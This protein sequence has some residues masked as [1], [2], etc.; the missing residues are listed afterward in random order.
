MLAGLFLV[1]TSSLLVWLGTAHKNSSIA[2]EHMSEKDAMWFPVIGSAVLLSLFFALKFLPKEIMNI[3]LNLLFLMTGTAGVYSTIH[4]GF[5][6]FSKAPKPDARKKDEEKEEKGKKAEKAAAGD[7]EAARG[8]RRSKE[9]SPSRSEKKER[10]AKKDPEVPEKTEKALPATSIRTTLIMDTVNFV[11]KAIEQANATVVSFVSK[12]GPVE[13]VSLAIA[14]AVNITYYFFKKNWVLS[15]I[16][17]ASF[18]IT[19][20]GEM[21]LDS[22]KTGLFLLTLLFFYDIFW[23]FYTPVMMSVAKGI[24][25]PIK[26][27]YP[28]KPGTPSLIGLGDIVVPGLYLGKIREFGRAESNSFI[29]YAGYAGYIGGLLLTFAVSLLTKSGQPALLYLCPATILTTFAAA[30]AFG[31]HKKM[32]EYRV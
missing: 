9:G 19:T 11:Q 25:L 10:G 18:C 15:N 20:L 2:V 29:F 28:S 1:G 23:V 7:K 21:K 8:K 32:Y 13:V 27:L 3:V 4:R 5:Y 6:L 26:I 31:K 17:A 14:L 12:I 22:T 16:I 30:F 24:D